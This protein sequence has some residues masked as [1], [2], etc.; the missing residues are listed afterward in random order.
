MLSRAGIAPTL[1][2]NRLLLLC[3]YLMVFGVS[4]CTLFP[5]QL[6]RSV[7][8]ANLKNPVV[9]I[10]CLWEP[11]EGRDPQG[12]PCRGFAGQVLF[13]GNKGGLPVQVHGEV[14]IY[15]FDDHG[16]L[17]EQAKPVHVFV[18]NEDAWNRHMKVSTFGP[19]YYVF[20][21][22]TRPGGYEAV[23]SVRVKL[24]PP[25]GPAVFSDAANIPLSGKPRPETSVEATAKVPEEK[26]PT[27]RTTSIPLD[28]LHTH[29]AD[30]AWDEERARQLLEQ[31]LLQQ[32]E[33]DQQSG[34]DSQR[35]SEFPSYDGAEHDSWPRLR[36][37]AQ[38]LLKGD[39]TESTN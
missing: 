30:H 31:F 11:S 9:K 25:D 18:F 16:T 8:E 4:G 27:I 7:P 6:W 5:K 37:K 22:Y 13:L 3:G 32:I 19:S 38:Q 20:V 33:K 23:C 2:I 34:S 15:V 1:C 36:I 12:M 21:P 10:L 28:S 17:E 14:S 35:F 24:S 26:A 39:E 29:P